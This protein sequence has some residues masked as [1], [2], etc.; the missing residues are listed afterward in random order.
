MCDLFLCIYILC[1]HRSEKSLIHRPIF[2]SSSISLRLS[3]F[4]SFVVI[5]IWLFV[6]GLRHP[7]QCDAC[8]RQI[9]NGF[10]GILL[11]ICTVLFHRYET[12][13]RLIFMISCRKPCMVQPPRHWFLLDHGGGYF[14]HKMSPKSVK[15]KKKKM[16]RKGKLQRHLQFGK[17]NC[18]N[19]N[20][21]WTTILVFLGKC[22]YSNCKLD[23]WRNFEISKKGK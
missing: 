14:S 17:I 8:L 7:E 12:S 5:N 6:K 1:F 13:W 3:V 2:I 11:N 21:K 9:Q 22:K 19:P 4:F 16:T 23:P 10:R 20:Q 15:K 18:C